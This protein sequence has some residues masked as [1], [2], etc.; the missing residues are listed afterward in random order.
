M[1]QKRINPIVLSNPKSKLEIEIR[2]Y[3]ILYND[4][5]SKNKPFNFY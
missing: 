4:Y 5:I 2:D 1:L 3:Y